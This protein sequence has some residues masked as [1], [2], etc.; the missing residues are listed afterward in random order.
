[1]WSVGRLVRGVVLGGLWVTLAGAR[2][3]VLAQALNNVVRPASNANAAVFT[4]PAGLA[5]GYSV[6]IRS[7]WN[8]PGVMQI[9]AIDGGED[10]TPNLYLRWSPARETEIAVEGN[11]P[12]KYRTAL[13][14]MYSTATHAILV[15]LPKAGDGEV[16]LALEDQPW[17]VRVSP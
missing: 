15:P 9:C 1:M 11:C 12:A 17:K 5:S 10:G 13:A 2:C 16:A 4:P 6:S 3:P 7:D 14:R 8:R